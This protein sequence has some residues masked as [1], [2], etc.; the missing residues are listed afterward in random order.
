MA[1]T[2]RG[3]ADPNSVRRAAVPKNSWKLSLRADGELLIAL[4]GAW[5]L[6]SS[7]YSGAEISHRLAAIPTAKTIAFNVNDLAAWDSVTAGP[8]VA[9][10]I[11]LTNFQ[12]ISPHLFLGQQLRRPM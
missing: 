2:D 8:E 9:A 6:A 3:F 1:A 10:R 11:P 5:V 7:S 12:Q 4:A